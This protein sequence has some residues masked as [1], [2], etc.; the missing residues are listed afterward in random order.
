[1]TELL[2][3]YQVNKHTMALLAAAQLEYETVVLEQERQLYVKQPPLQ[4]IKKA[5]LDAG[6]T[7]DGRRLAII[8]HTGSRKK[9]PIPINPEK[10]IFAFPTCSPASFSCY[11]IFYR[12]IFDIET[13]P[14]VENSSA[15]STIVFTNGQQL[16]MKESAYVLKKQQLRTALA[17]SKFSGQMLAVHYENLPSQFISHPLNGRLYQP[18]SGDSLIDGP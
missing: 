16:P 12:H 3:D 10:N 18:V 6:S 8:Y 13:G 2:A 15:Q 11:W 7:Y 4:L 9:V 5:C 17:I 1:M 14:S